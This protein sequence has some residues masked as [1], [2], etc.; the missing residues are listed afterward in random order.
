MRCE[1]SIEKS[2]DFLCFTNRSSEYVVFVYL[3]SL[4]PKRKLKPMFCIQPLT[5]KLF[6]CANTKHKRDVM[7]D[8]GMLSYQFIPT[9]KN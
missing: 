3:R 9:N 6:D 5:C 1:L 4:A 7:L 2:Q 8:L